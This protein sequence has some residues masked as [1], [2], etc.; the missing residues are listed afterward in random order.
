MARSRA[1]LDP[2]RMADSQLWA[3]ALT[4][5]DAVRYRHQRTF[6]EREA[7]LDELET[8]LREL[9]LRGTQLHLC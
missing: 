1:K 4:L 7:L 8:V 2:Q 3:R 6:I 9:R 5:T